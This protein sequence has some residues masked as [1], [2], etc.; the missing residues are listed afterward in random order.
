MLWRREN[1]A[2]AGNRTPA[3]QPI[4]RDYT[5]WTFLA[6]T[7]VCVSWKTIFAYVRTK[8]SRADMCLRVKVNDKNVLCRSH[9]SCIGYRI[10]GSHSS[11]YK[12]FCLLGCNS[13]LCSACYHFIVLVSYPAYSSAM[14]ME[15]TCS[16]EMSVDFQHTTLPYIPECS[17]LHTAD[18]LCNLN[19]RYKLQYGLVR[20]IT[21]QLLL[22]LFHNREM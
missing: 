6:T 14:K 3:V 21:V 20:I 22:R 15:A 1:L 7:Y 12:E 19:S 13:V 16:S 2:P 9:N 17:T 5:D 11:G 8:P 4:A 18:L 10:W